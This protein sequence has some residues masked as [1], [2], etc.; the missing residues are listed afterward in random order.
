MLNPSPIYEAWLKAE[1]KQQFI[2]ELDDMAKE[3]LLN[4]NAHHYY[5]KLEYPD[6]VEFN[7]AWV[8]N[9]TEAMELY[10]QACM[11]VKAKYPKPEENN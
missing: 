9:D 1:N 11:D 8:K 10:R 3:S 6:A 5:R 7:D 4:S 2:A